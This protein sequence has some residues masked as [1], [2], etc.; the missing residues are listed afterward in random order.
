M[1]PLSFIPWLTS[2]AHTRRWH[3]LVFFSSLPL[4]CHC[5]CYDEFTNRTLK[6]I[7]VAM[8]SRSLV[9]NIGIQMQDIVPADVP[10][11]L[12]LYRDARSHRPDLQYPCQDV[13][14]ACRETCEW[15]LLAC[16]RPFPS[17]HQ[18]LHTLFLL[19]I[20]KFLVLP[21]FLSV[22]SFQKSAKPPVSPFAWNFLFISPEL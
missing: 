22:T 12:K 3:L 5:F 21:L 4:S 18:Q 2:S 14:R 16:C 20:L 1:S 19:S 17:C 6:A 10:C 7:Q 13:A 9:M 11:P 15:L 8:Y